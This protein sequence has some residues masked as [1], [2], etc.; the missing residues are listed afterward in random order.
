M[1]DNIKKY[2]ELHDQLKN[3]DL[4]SEEADE[5]RD[6]M[7]APWYALTMDEIEFME[8]MWSKESCETYGHNPNGVE[9]E[10]FVCKECGSRVLYN[11]G[12]S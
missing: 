5:L 4:E 10:E 8:K 6:R 9:H 1:T 3:M 2:L 7:D 11:I 12:D